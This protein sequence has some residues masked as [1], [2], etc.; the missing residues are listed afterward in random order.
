MKRAALAVALA[1]A[2]AMPAAH[3]QDAG[4]VARVLRDG[5]SCVGC[6]LLQIDLSYRTV[7]GR[8]YSNARLMQAG[9]VAGIYDR[10]RFRGANLRFLDGTAARFSGADFRGADL[11]QAVFVGAYLGAADFTRATLAGANFSGAEM[12]A[13]RGLTQA[14]L[15]A[16][17][18]DDATTLPAGLTIPRC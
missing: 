12:D 9:M 10:T 11:S 4:A 17:C 15:D 16:A 3:A 13:A 7:A 2:V 8:D 6:D 18:G 5:G 1:F 14:Q